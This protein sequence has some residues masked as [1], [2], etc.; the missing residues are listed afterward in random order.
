M[1]VYYKCTDLLDDQVLLTGL[2]AGALSQVPLNEWRSASLATLLAQEQGLF[3]LKPEVRACAPRVTAA[4][5][6]CS[7][8]CMMCNAPVQKTGR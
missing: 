1:Q 2:A 3:G 8:W 7:S 4:T 6:P 5:M